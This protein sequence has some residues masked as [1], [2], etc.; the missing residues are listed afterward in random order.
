MVPTPCPVCTAGRA[1]GSSRGEQGA[2]PI[3]LPLERGRGAQGL[4][5]PR[6]PF[7][8]SPTSQ[9]SSVP[10]EGGTK[11]LPVSSPHAFI[12]SLIYSSTHSLIHSSIH[13]L[14]HSFTHSSVHSFS[15]SLIYLFTIYS[16]IHSSNNA[17]QGQVPGTAEVPG[18]DIDTPPHKGTEGSAEHKE[19]T[20]GRLPRGRDPRVGPEAG[21][22]V[23]EAEGPV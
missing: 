6:S 10:S 12:P 21:A 4:R 14:I 9:G 1:G 2:C 23:Q 13:S 8:S 11:R 18:R 3:S 7:T 19:K 15:H 5:S 22:G 16:F 17:D 20:G